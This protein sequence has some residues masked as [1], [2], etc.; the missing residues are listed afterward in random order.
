MP[1]TKGFTF[2]VNLEVSGRTDAELGQ[3]GLLPR[4][5]VGKSFMLLECT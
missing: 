2:K 3:L 1:P 5:S 4:R